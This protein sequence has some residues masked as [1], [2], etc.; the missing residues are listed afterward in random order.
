MLRRRIFAVLLMVAYMP[1][2]V[3]SVVHVHRVP[4]VAV[5]DD[6]VHHVEHPSHFNPGSL[7][8]C[9]C[10]FCMQLQESYLKVASLSVVLMAAGLLMVWRRY[11][12]RLVAAS[13]QYIR[14][15]APPMAS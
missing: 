12:V 13:G 15:R 6:C 14:F 7:D 11:G 4:Q 1:L 10:L 3:V 9:R 2:L 8:S 5:C